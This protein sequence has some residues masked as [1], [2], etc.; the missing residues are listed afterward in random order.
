MMEIL[1]ADWNDIHTLIERMQSRS[2]EQEEDI[3][4]S[5]NLLRA[6][7]GEGVRAPRWASVRQP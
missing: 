4:N 5:C 2:Y 3:C 7:H 1:D 6:I